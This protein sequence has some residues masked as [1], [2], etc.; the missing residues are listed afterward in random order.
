MPLKDRVRI[1]IFEAGTP[2]HSLHRGLRGVD[3]EFE[4]ASEFEGADSN[5]DSKLSKE[6]HEAKLE[7]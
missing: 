3:I 5:S 1:V 6:K 2:A 4:D 7:H